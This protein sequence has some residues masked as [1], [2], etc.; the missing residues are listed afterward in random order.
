MVS[1]GHSLT[2]SLDPNSDF[3]H[4]KIW[5]CLQ[6]EINPVCSLFS[7]VLLFF[8]FNP[9]SFVVSKEFTIFLLVFCTSIEL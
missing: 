8:I 3:L 7:F 5:I 1:S 9:R 4:P 6:N 2:P